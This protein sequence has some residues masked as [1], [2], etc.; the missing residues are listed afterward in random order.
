M[1]FSIKE[2]ELV[3]RL[4]DT[5]LGQLVRALALAKLSQTLYEASIAKVTY[6][7]DGSVVIAI[8]SYPKQG[9]TLKKHVF[10]TL[11]QGTKDQAPAFVTEFTFFGAGTQTLTITN[12]SEPYPEKLYQIKHEITGLPGLFANRTTF[13]GLSIRQFKQYAPFSAW[14]PK[15]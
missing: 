4:D 9:E 5:Q 8:P 14:L 10:E 2:S 12:I 1:A 3:D 11:L 13:S 15:G 6:Q 7:P